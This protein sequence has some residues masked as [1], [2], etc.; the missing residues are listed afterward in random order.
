MGS[1]SHNKLKHSKKSEKMFNNSETLLNKMY[2]QRNIKIATR[3]GYNASIKLFCDIVEDPKGLGHL[4]QSYLQEEDERVPVRD[5]LIK[6]HLLEYRTFL[7]NHF[8]TD[9]TVRHYL[10][11]ITSL[12]RHFN[13][14]IPELPKVKLEKGYVSSFND[15]PTHNMIRTACEQ[16]DIFMKSVILFMSSSGTA[17][18]E[19]LSITVGMFLK[20]Y[21]EYL[22]TPAKTENIQETL[23]KLD[24][25]HDLIPMIYLRRIK[26]DKWYVT[27]CSPEASYYLIQYL[28]TRENLQWDEPIFPVTSSMLLTYFQDLNDKNKWG[29]VGKYRRFRAH[30]LR[31]FMASNIGLPRDQVDSL[32][33]RAKDEIQEAYFKQDPKKLKE[34]YM[35]NMKNI[36]IY[37]NWGYGTTPSEFK[38]T[39]LKTTLNRGEVEIVD[40]SKEVHDPINL[41]PVSEE[42]MEQVMVA[43]T[44]T[45][46]GGVSVA[47]ELLMYSKL[48]DKGLLSVGEFNLIKQKLLRSVI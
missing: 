23:K 32:Q 31:K 25:R 42:T 27:C 43:S 46:A 2:D 17:K 14:E 13:V 16:S 8:D 30:A 4:I 44:I 9:R 35:G 29:T 7:S 1:G 47:K 20:G 48:I 12:F 26:T 34:I 21:D 11:K 28:K 37:N 3:K 39:N 15:L 40:L 5:R 6:K 36:L 10:S 19:A 38:Q 45:D 33:G 22:D 18:A 41:A 24:E